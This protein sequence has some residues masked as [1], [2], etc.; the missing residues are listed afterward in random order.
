MTPSLRVPGRALQRLEA[1]AS[2]LSTVLL[3]AEAPA[4]AGEV[5]LVRGS[6]EPLGLAIADPAHGLVR[7]V[8]APGEPF[9]ALDAAF[10][11]ARLA[12]AWAWRQRLGL[13]GVDEAHRLVNGA[14][15]GLPGLAVDRYGPWVVVHVHSR[16]LWPLARLV[17]AAA[18]QA[19]GLRGAVLKLR[20]RG[21]AAQGRLE[22]E[23]VGDPPPE[24]L[25]VAEGPR[26]FEVHLE[27]GL[28]VGLFTDMRRHRDGL[29]RTWTPEPVA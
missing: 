29:D 25:V 19:C 26:R 2:E 4:A 13:G 1:G 12:R 17:A 24:R 16:V 11:D 6:G 15:D 8:T 28:N 3:G 22:Q 9:V 27:S 5:R 21:A 18:L 23:V 7:V 20:E 14:G 10:A